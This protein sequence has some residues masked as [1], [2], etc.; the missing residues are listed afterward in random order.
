MNVYLGTL[1]ISGHILYIWTGFYI[2]YTIGLQMHVATYRNT[3]G[4]AK[5]RSSLK[6]NACIQSLR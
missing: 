3:I 5:L 6:L 1:C 4:L 2:V